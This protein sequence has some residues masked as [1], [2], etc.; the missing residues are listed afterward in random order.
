MNPGSFSSNKF[1]SQQIASD[2]L[3]PKSPYASTRVN[4]G[5]SNQLSLKADK[6]KKKEVKQE[7]ETKRGTSK[8]SGSH[9]E[10]TIVQE[11]TAEFDLSN[12]K[13]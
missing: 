6:L 13:K 11:E 3:K 1:N 5:S 9:H 8:F 7:S 12:D 10:I 2:S 4:H